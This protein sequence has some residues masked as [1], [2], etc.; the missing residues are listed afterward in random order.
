[1]KIKQVQIPEDLFMKITRLAVCY[2]DLP[3]EDVSQLITEIR[4]GVYD[5]FDRMAQ[6]DLYST[7]KTD[8]SPAE[9][10]RAR[11]EYLQRAGIPESFIRH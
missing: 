5:K 6:R 9:R 3:D 11:L 10:E 2:E 4:Q 8:P 1:M 7:Y